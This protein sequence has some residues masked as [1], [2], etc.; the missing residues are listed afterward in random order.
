[1]SQQLKTEV[2]QLVQAIEINLVQQEEERAYIELEA[3]WNHQINDFHTADC[4]TVK[5]HYDE[6]ACVLNNL[7]G[8]CTFFFI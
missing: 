7:Y 4:W 8:E 5:T 1:M 6:F 3:W 2:I